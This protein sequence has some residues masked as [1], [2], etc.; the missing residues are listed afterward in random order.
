MDWIEQPMV[1]TV[2]SWTRTWHRFGLT[3]GLD[4]PFVSVVAELGNSGIRLMGRLEDPLR[5]DPAIG[6][7]L[8]G[9]IGA[10]EVNGRAIPTII[11]SRTA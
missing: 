3:E 2:F 4:L 6:E 1:A 11:W 10:T 7:A 8:I 5:I 9:A